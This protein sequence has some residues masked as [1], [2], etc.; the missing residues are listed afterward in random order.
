MDLTPAE[1]MLDSTTRITAFNDSEEIS[2]GTGFFY[3]FFPHPGH[4]VPCLVTNKHVIEGANAIS[5]VF[6]IRDDS[7]PNGKSGG[8]IKL[9]MD[10]NHNTVIMHPSS[11]VDLCAIPILS[12][13]NRAK[14]AGHPVWYVYLDEEL[15]PKKQ[16]W[17]YFDAIED[18]TMIGCPR[19]LFDDYNNS[20]LVRRGI[21]ST[22]VGRPY[23]GQNEFVV[24]M[25]CFPGSSGS[26]V[27]IYDKMGFFDKKQN[28]HILGSRLFLVGILYS[29]PL[30]TNKGQIVLGTVPSVEVASMMH[31][32]NVIRADELVVLNKEIKFRMGL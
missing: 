28:S 26:P 4:Y 19:G 27:F 21:T 20:P 15:I 9:K 16:D 11:D 22:P 12:T 29:G 23:N 10:I 24:D 17:R 32:G 6:H 30:I 14:E 7:K 13:I 5:V 31:L 18:V 1:Q 2:T 25:A 8:L 3:Q